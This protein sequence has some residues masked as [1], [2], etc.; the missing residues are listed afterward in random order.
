MAKKKNKVKWRHYHPHWTRFF[1]WT[2]RVIAVVITLLALIGV[3]GTLY[4]RAVLNSTPAVTEEALR[5]DP[6]SNMYAANGELIWSSTKNRRVYSEREELP[7]KYVEMLLATE[8]K[9]FYEDPGFSPKG[10]A[11]AFISVA[12]KVLGTGEIRGGSSIEQQ[13]I[14]LT[15]FSTSESDVTVERKIQE[16]FLAN[17]LY[18]NYTKD[19]ILE[20][21]VNKLPLSE[22]SFG[23][24]TL[25]RTY[26]NKT[27]DELTIAQIALIVGTGQAPSAYNVYENPDRAQTRRDDVLYIS[28]NDGI[29][30]E[31]TYR[32]AL[33]EPIDQDLMPRFWQTELV[34]AKVIQH[35]AYVK[36][37][38]KQLKDM[39]YNLDHT[40]L[41]IYTALDIELNNYVKDIYD[42]HPEY[43][44]DSQQSA[45]TLIDNPTGNVIA[46]IGGRGIN[47]VDSY[48]RATQTNRST[49][50]STKAFIYAGGIEKYGWATNQPF[51]G[52]DYH[53][54][55]TNMWAGNY[56]GQQVGETNLQQA[57][58]QSYNT[59]VLRAYDAVGT[60]DMKRTLSRFGFKQ[61]ENIT[62]GSALGL[63]ASTEE[64][65]AAFRV[66]SEDGIYKK[67]NYVTKIIFPDDSEKII[68]SKEEQAIEP[69][70]AGL[71]RHVLSG[72]SYLDSSNDNNVSIEGIPQI[73]KTGTVGY[74]NTVNHPYRTVMDL[75]VGGSTPSTSLAIWHGYERPMTDG[76]LSEDYMRQRKFNLFRNI[77]S[78]AS[79]GKDN[80]N[81]S[82]PEGLQLVGGEGL[83]AHYRPVHIDRT[84]L[85]DKPVDNNI[86]EATNKY[87]S[88]NSQ[89]VVRGDDEYE[90][91]PDNYMFKEWED[92]VAARQEEVDSEIERLK[93]ESE[94]AW[95]TWEEE[96]PTYEGNVQAEEA[97]VLQLQNEYNERVRELEAELERLAEET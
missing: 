91:I 61:T 53:Y 77:L 78:E 95:A 59:P 15:V 47:E 76:W 63:D 25:A 27:L 90:I 33:D 94:Q 5:S 39:G 68:E 40:P 21:Y 1:K 86:T 81:W 56:G 24:Q 57:L 55:G 45:A 29:L 97:K 87:F 13:L 16:F 64:V 10:L 85:A 36:E 71:L 62:S 3:G 30:D 65:A 48:N 60:D 7:D 9:E 31:E 28:R 41:Q 8:Q 52:A 92:D 37:S 83:S 22:N 44:Q 17:Q 34:E 79:K 23:A 42:N 4:V 58:R 93:E 49:G 75:W 20:F 38:L 14:K 46:Q 84:Y 88:D 80:S 12:Q 11:N 2:G 19:E 66:L 74:P 51:S 43:F 73:A 26:Y 6:S 72:V 54:A 67:P 32:T 50:S 70:T 69:S 89:E 96:K 82:N 18:E 35:D